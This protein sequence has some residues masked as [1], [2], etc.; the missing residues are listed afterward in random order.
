[1]S[2]ELS[3]IIINWNGWEDTLR[4]LESLSASTYKNFSVTVVDNGST[5]GSF[6][7][8]KLHKDGFSFQVKLLKSFVNTGFTGGCNIA[9][10]E[11]LKGGFRYVFLL[12]NDASLHPD[13]LSHLLNTSKSTG[14]AIVGATVVGDDGE[15]LFAGSR[16]PHQ[17]FGMGKIKDRR[18]SWWPSS[19]AQGCAILIRMDAV[20]Q[21]IER[22]GEF[23]D[24]S[25]F[26]YT[27]ETDFCRYALSRGHRIVISRDALVRH[28]PAKVSGGAG[29]PFSYYYLTRNR[30]Y[31]AQRWL[32]FGWRMLFHLYYLPSRLLIQSAGYS[33]GRRGTLKAVM[34]GIADGYRGVKGRKAL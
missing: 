12:N 11:A 24:S 29:N 10:K 15:I 3:I 1:V 9:V 6:K 2:P 31:L 5:D 33:A 30:I 13:A 20:R 27:E 32:G 28:A 16:W 23:L 26:M 18:K 19:D 34:K 21:R 8:L 14:A 17:L 22:C 4:C 7:M 25:L